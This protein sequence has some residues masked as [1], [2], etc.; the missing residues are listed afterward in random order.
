[1]PEV[2][3]CVFQRVRARAFGHV[4]EIDVGQMPGHMRR[5]EMASGNQIEQP[6]D[7]G[8]HVAEHRVEMPRR[9]LG[10]PGARVAD[11]APEVAAVRAV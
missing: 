6:E 5:L 7:M 4:T 3:A 1:M 9:I 11:D 8:R 2:A 10:A